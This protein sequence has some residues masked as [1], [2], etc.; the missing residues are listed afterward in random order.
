M[1]QARIERAACW[2]RAVTVA[3]ILTRR[4]GTLPVPS[5]TCNGTVTARIDASTAVERAAGLPWFKW[6][7][8]ALYNTF[9]ILSTF[10]QKCCSGFEMSGVRQLPNVI[11]AMRRDLT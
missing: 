4:T 9:G 8:C 3:T 7:L 10:R 5:A 6:Y 1:A 2:L 11:A